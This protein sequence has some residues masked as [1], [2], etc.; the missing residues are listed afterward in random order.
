MTNDKSDSPIDDTEYHSDDE[1]DK[2]S[3]SNSNKNK[4]VRT[5]F[6]DHQK[7]MLEYLFEYNPYP[8]PKETEDISIKLSLSESVVKVWF[9]NK[10]SRDKQRKFSRKSTKDKNSQIYSLPKYAALLKNLN[11]LR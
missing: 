9:Q 3:K 1:S 11:L 5:S 7:S 8:D 2:V 6:S 4:K 10:R